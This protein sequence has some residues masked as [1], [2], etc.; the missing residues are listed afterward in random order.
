[1]DASILSFDVNAKKSAESFLD[2]NQELVIPVKFIFY[3]GKPYYPNPDERLFVT[4]SGLNY[5]EE[6]FHISQLAYEL[7]SEAIQ[8][9]IGTNYEIKLNK[10]TIVD[11]L[12]DRI[13]ISLAI[14]H[15]HSGEMGLGES[16]RIGTFFE[17]IFKF[18][19]EFIEF[20]GDEE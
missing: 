13:K 14:T 6:E 16:I 15:K 10:R 1:M 7:P 20:D 8:T 2:N 3:R 4:I 9:E 5:R 12:I 18:N 17:T 11:N 19:K